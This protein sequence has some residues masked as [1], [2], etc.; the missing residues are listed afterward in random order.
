MKI[1]KGDNVMVITGKD[2]VALPDRVIV[3]GMNLKKRHQKARRA[4]TKGQ[5]VEKAAPIHVSNVMIIDPETKKPTR[6]GFK[7]LDG[8]KVR[9]SRKSGREI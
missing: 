4:N 9:I 5:V 3:E 8:K 7:I 2:K 1:H 6:I